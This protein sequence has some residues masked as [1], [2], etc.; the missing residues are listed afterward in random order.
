M[1]RAERRAAWWYR[2]RGWRIVGANIPT[3]NHL[4]VLVQDG[5]TTFVLA[6]DTSYDEQ[7]MLAGK[8]DGV[9]ADD[10]VASATLDAIRRL[11][12]TRPTVYLP[13]HD[14]QSAIRLAS[15]RLVED[16]GAAR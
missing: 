13:T 12:R 16:H 7:L 14:P 11:A 15:R 5:D 4:S 1:N 3:A 10:D 6:G 2:V 9:S 8:V